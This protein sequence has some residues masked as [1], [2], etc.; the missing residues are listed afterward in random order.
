MA[1]HVGPSCTRAST[2][3][4]IHIDRSRTKNPVAAL[5]KQGLVALAI[6]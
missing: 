2:A 3:R 4:G 1:S 6:V 5:V